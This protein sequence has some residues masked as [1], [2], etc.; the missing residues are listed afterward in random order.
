MKIL[1]IVN[2]LLNDMHE[3]LYNQKESNGVWMDALLSDFKA[4]GEHQLLIATTLPIKKTVRYE[5]DGVTYYALPDT[6]PI[7]YNENKKSNVRAWQELLD[8]EKPDLIHVFGTEFSH[9]LCALRCNKNI[10]VILHMQGILQSIA[11]FYQTGL[12]NREF[13][14][15]TLR[16]WLKRDSMRLQ[17]KRYAK[18]A[19]KEKEVIRLSKNV[20]SENEWCDAYVK[21]VDSRTKIFH[22]AESMNSVFFE[23]PW[24]YNE[25]QKY[26]IA[27][28]A[29]GYPIKGLHVLLKAVALL[30]VKYPQI[31]LHIPGESM[32]ETSSFKARLRRNGY[33]KHIQKLIRGL[34]LQEQIVWIGRKTQKELAEHNRRMH[35]FVMPSVIENHSNSLKEAMMQGIPCVASAVGGV[36]SYAKHGENALLYNAE[37]FEVLA[38]NV[39]KLFDNDEYA[40]QLASKGRERMLSMHQGAEIYQ[41]TIDIYC[42]VLKDQ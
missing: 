9:G 32:A 17:Q 12:T 33:T 39:E 14:T 16:D 2:V 7:L 5:K 37:E 10:P 3:Y 6:Y 8:T 27:C 21:A 36:T 41:Q 1:W 28:N 25:K 19:L 42:Q 22:R 24:L 30:K 20:I 23:T 35:V 15:R 4:K 18:K 11:R 29:S 13:G 34:G 31:R 40:Q 38:A 26:T